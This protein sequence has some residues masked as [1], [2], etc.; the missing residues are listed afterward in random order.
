MFGKVFE[1]MYQGSMRGAGPCVLSVWTWI[2]THAKDGFVSF[3]FDE[4]ANAIGADKVPGMVGAVISASDV[5]AI[6]KWLGQPDPESASEAEE[7]RRLICVRPYTYF[8]VNHERYRDLR[9]SGDRKEYMR[10]YMR[11]RRE[12]EKKNGS[13][14]KQNVSNGKTKSLTSVNS[15]AQHSHTQSQPNPILN[16]IPNSS[17][18]P[19]NST[20]AEPL[21]PCLTENESARAMGIRKGNSMKKTAEKSADS[22]PKFFLQFWA[23]YPGNRRVDRKKC[24]AF[25]LKEN[26]EAR[27]EEIAAGFHRWE[28][29]R[30]WA[31]DG[32]KFI[33]APLVWLHRGAWEAEPPAAGEGDLGESETGEPYIA[34]YFEDGEWWYQTAGEKAAYDEMQAQNAAKLAPPA[35]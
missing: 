35:A 2:F 32:G 29:S 24:L 12:E 9:N 20:E 7:G 34:R 5:E 8:V 27:A 26:L 4:V 30:Q 11:K 1:T 15:L 16:P 13:D 25:W 18:V 10:D 3:H 19:L 14:V 28:A 17:G 21:L 22:A 23:K 6:V 31:E 33:P